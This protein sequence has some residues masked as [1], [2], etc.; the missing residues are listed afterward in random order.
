[1]WTIAA[2]EFFVLKVA[3]L[4]GEL[5]HASMSRV[6]GYLGAWPGMD[7]RIFLGPRHATRPALG[8]LIAALG[9]FA[10]GIALGG[11]AV[12]HATAGAPLLVG[13]VGMLGVI[14]TL[15]F[16]V[17]HVVSWLWRAAGVDAP[18]IMRAPIAATSLAEF[19]GG[20]WNVAFA[21]GARRFVVRPLAR[22]VGA[23][24]AGL[25]VFALSGV[26]HET[27][28]SFPA[29]GGWGGPT[30]Y[31]LL[32][33]LGVALEKSAAGVRVGLGRGVRGW[34][35]TLLFTAAPIPLLFHA[36]FVRNVIVP[37]YRSLAA[38]LP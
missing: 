17:F 15:H 36:P 10:A 8:E 30:L 19:W 28:I 1:M 25:A 6:A 20:R 18:P 12:V 38:F 16:G 21:D 31:F 14:F 11:W 7:A 26:V 4:P 5:A 29:R 2:T 23:H 35:W 22:R 32:Q 24:W 37:F 27:V 9:V 3:T 34:M 33:A 13:V